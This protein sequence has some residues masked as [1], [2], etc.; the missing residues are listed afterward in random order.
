MGQDI[1]TGKVFVISA[2]SATGKTTLIRRLIDSN[3]DKVDIAISVTTRP[4]RV[5]ERDGYDYRF[6]SKPEF[7][8]RITKGDML[9]YANVHGNFYGSSKT[10]IKNIL[11][12]GHIPVLIIDVQG[13]MNARKTL[14]GAKSI[15]IMPPNA[16]AL[17]T[18]MEKRGTDSMETRWH[19][20]QTAHHELEFA[21]HYD[22]F[23]VN[24]DLDRAVEEMQDIVINGKKPHISHAE[25]VKRAADLLDKLQHAPWYR[26]LQQSYETSST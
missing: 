20:L 25:G 6:V 9:E 18:R 16:D 7:E 12:K 13:W 11:D 19:R 10:E 22:F 17:W 1:N 24:D 26:K 3:P 5:G 14:G 21:K 23:I 8:K 4:I 15:F 2:P